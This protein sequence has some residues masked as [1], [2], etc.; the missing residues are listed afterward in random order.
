MHT[1]ETFQASLLGVYPSIDTFAFADVDLSY[2]V[3]ITSSIV[4]LDA[5]A[6]YDG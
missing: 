3:I 1:A 5:I 6:I 2:I 4:A